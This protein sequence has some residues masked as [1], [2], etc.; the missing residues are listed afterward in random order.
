MFSGAKYQGG[1]KA[2]A[3]STDDQPLSDKLCLILCG[4]TY[5]V[6]Q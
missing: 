3:K 2:G 1:D 4:E 6:W 5:S